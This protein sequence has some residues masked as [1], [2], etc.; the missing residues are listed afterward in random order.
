MKYNVGDVVYAPVPFE[1]GKGVK[2]RPV[3]ILKIIPENKRYVFAECYSDKEHYDRT[4]GV[5][6]KEGTEVFNEMGLK[7]TSFITNSIKAIYEVYI[8]EKWGV[9]NNIDALKER[10][11]SK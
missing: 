11:K 7:E 6:I 5:L 3:V 8:I 1:D 4:K 9:Y 2:A 10:L